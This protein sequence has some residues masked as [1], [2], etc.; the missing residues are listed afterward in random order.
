VEDVTCTMSRARQHIKHHAANTKHQAPSTERQ[1]V[2]FSGA[3]LRTPPSNSSAR[4]TSGHTPSRHHSP[5]S[6]V[7]IGTASS[8]SSR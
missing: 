8:R 7:A 6:G 2:L 5:Q 4:S 1:T 3:F